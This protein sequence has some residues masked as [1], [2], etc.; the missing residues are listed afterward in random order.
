MTKNSLLSKI[1]MTSTFINPRFFFCVQ[2]FYMNSRNLY[3]TST[4]HHFDTILLFRSKSSE[5]KVF[6]FIYH[7]F[8]IYCIYLLLVQESKIRSVINT[9]VDPTPA[10]PRFLPGGGGGT[11]FGGA[12]DLETPRPTTPDP[13]PRRICS[14][15]PSVVPI[16]EKAENVP[17]KMDKKIK[18]FRKNFDKLVKFS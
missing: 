5:W 3:P 4:V 14:W 17:P 1:Y 9:R 7:I 13:D 11:F 8:F 16:L 12:L 2:Q 15:P 10:R 6:Y 18:I